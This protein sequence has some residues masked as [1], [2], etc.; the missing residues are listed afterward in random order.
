MLVEE[1]L[2]D[3][4]MLFMIEENTTQLDKNKE[5]SNFKSICSDLEDIQGATID[6][7]LYSI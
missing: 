3:S 7:T 6:N 5:L 1:S 4:D 2:K